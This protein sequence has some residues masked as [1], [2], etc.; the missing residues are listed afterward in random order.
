MRLR[1]RERWGKRQRDGRMERQ[2]KRERERD[3][4]CICDLFAVI[5]EG[6]G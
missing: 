3:F 6:F 1:D 4:E 2:I 5:R